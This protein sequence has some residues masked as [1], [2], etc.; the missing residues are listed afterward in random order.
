[1]SMSKKDFISLADE[2]RPLGNRVDG[3]ITDAL[4]R[5]MRSVNPNFKEDRWRE[6]LAGTCGPSG[7][8][9]K[10]IPMRNMRDLDNLR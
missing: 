5:F 1:M 10:G 9:V 7:G 3:D 4:C 6:Y 2:L 8:K